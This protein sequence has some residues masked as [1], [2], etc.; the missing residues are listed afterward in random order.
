MKNISIF[1]LTLNP[2]HEKIIEKLSYIPVGLG[3][4]IFSSDCF[5]DKKGENVV[6]ISSKTGQGC[7][8]LLIAIDT[9]LMK[10]RQIFDIKIPMSE[11]SALAWLYRHGAVLSR[12]EEKT[13]LLLKVSMEPGTKAKFQSNFGSLGLKATLF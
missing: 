4:K 5:T 13:D 6:S 11:G 12:T 7:D 9:M 3:D 10:Q 2:K 8:K 1:C